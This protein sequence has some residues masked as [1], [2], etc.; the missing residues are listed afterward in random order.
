M[1]LCCLCDTY[2]IVSPPQVVPFAKISAKTFAESSAKTFA[3]G[4]ITP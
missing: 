2:C 1:L 4:R 3:T